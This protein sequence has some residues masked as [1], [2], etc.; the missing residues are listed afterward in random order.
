LGSVRQRPD[1]RCARFAQELYPPCTMTSNITEWERGWFYLRNEGAGL[2]LHWQG[3]E[4][5]DQR[6]VSWR[7]SFLVLGV[8]RLTH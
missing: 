6:L 4:G 3:V 2:P 8:A 7:V 5:E 1:V